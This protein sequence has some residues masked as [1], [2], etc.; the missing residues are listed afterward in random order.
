ML[1]TVDM[2]YQTMLAEVGQRA[3]DDAWTLGFLPTGRFVKVR[4]KDRDYWYF[5]QPDAKA[6][7]SGNMSAPSKI[8]RSRNASRTSPPS[9]P[10]TGHA[11]VW[12]PASRRTAACWRPTEAQA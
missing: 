3:M 11:D 12:S 9:K 10:T 5:D 6:V 8:L 1:K 7:K 2:M 4:V